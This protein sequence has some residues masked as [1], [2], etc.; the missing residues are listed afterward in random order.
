MPC[1]A[2]IRWLFMYRSSVRV[3]HT[4][5]TV[6]FAGTIMMWIACVVFA[7]VAAINRNK[8]REVVV[9]QEQYYVMNEAA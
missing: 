9:V 5:A 4:L 6:S 1:N 2:G 7:I 3:N 8:P